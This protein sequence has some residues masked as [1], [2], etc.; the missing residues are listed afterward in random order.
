[1]TDSRAGTSQIWRQKPR[2]GAD[3]VSRRQ[4][5]SGSRER[6]RLDAADHC[7]RRLLPESLR[8]IPRRKRCWGRSGRKIPARG[9][10][11]TPNRSRKAHR[12]ETVKA[13]LRSGF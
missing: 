3:S 4:G 7:R 2:A 6:N 1:M 10:R 9:A 5:A 12:F 11:S 13:V 8:A